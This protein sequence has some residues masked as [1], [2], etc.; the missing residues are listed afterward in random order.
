M[1]GVPGPDAAKRKNLSIGALFSGFFQAGI[2]GFGG[3]LPVARR[4]IVEQRQ[5]MD[6]AA[7][8]D[9]FSLCQF[10]PGANVVNFA[11]AF[12]ARNRGLA[13][14]A[15]AVAGLLS[16]P[17]LIVLCI[18]ALYQRFGAIPIVQH[19]LGGLAAAASGLVLGTAM[20]IA[21]PVCRGLRQIVI[22][23]LV[24]GLVILG[25]VSLPLTML[26]VLPLSIALAWRPP[27]R[28]K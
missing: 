20:K 12:G 13:G 2:L 25:H 7:F 3:V 4:M 21:A 19:G 26:L 14:A 11:F 28:R 16:A 17:L 24:F 9:L 27:A 8:N 10:L 18:S 23:A 15:A 6:A 22:A 1:N 5:W